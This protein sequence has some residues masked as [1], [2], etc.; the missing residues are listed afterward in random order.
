[1]SE[2]KVGPVRFGGVVLAVILLA[3]E[4]ALPAEGKDPA[5]ETVLIG[6]KEASGM[7]IKLEIE[8]AQAMYMPMH[9]SWMEMKPE[10]GEIYH[11]EV[12]PEDPGSKTRLSYAVVKFRS[13]NTSNGKVVEKDLHPMWGG[14][15]LHYAANGALP[16]DGA[17]TA[18]VIVEP[19]T[20]ARGPK[21][22]DMW[23]KPAQADFEFTMRKGRVVP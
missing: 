18:T 4:V 19:P 10:K 1:M 17:Y 14:S 3:G 22:K 6:V 23:K 20:F 8:P 15:G 5:K 13:V 11:F 2:R 9:G 16:G 21:N 12:K 7:A